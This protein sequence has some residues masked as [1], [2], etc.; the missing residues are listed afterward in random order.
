MICQCDMTLCDTLPGTCQCDLVRVSQSERKPHV[1]DHNSPRPT[2]YAHYVGA[3]RTIGGEAEAGG[4][5][6]GEWDVAAEV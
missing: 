6:A 2:T 3:G 1:H 5:V 4:T